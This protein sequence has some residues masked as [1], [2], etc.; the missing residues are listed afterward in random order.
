ME[1]ADGEVIG[2][3][4]DEKGEW[5]RVRCGPDIRSVLSRDPDLR[6]RARDVAIIPIVKLKE[7]HRAVQGTTADRTLQWMLTPSDRQKLKEHGHDR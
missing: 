5:I 6:E 4:S 3:F 2:S 1:W 7:H